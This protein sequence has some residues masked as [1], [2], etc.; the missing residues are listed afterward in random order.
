MARPS[1]SLIFALVLVAAVLCIYL[2]GIGNELVF[3]DSR[4]TDGTVLGQYGSLFTFKPRM[5]SYGSFVWLETLFGSGWWKQ[6]AF[7]IALHLATAF[8][9]YGLLRELFAQTRYSPEDEADPKFSRSRTAALQVGVALFALNPVAVYAVGYLTQRSIVMATLFSVLACW[10]FVRGIASGR[11]WWHLLALIAYLAAVLSKEYAAMIAA[12]ALPLYVYVRRPER[13]TIAIVAGASLALLVAV[14][15]LFFGVYG[16]LVGRLFDERSVAFAR[17]LE[18]LQPGITGRIY[19]LSVF[20]EAALFFKYGLLWFLPNVQWMSLDLRPAFP[21]SY[22]AFPQWLGALGYVALLGGSVWLLIKRRG[23]WS[24]AA[25]LLLFPLLLYPTEFATVWLQD[26][27]VL[28]RSYLWAIAL[29]GLV[30]L[31]LIGFSPRTVYV[32][33]TVVG[34][35]FGVLALDRVLSLK[36]EFSAWSDAAEKIDANAPANAVGRWRPFLNLGAWHL[37]KGLLEQAEGNFQTAIALGDLAGNARFN[38]GVTYQQ[39]KKHEQ[40]LKELAAAEAEGFK[41]QMLY[42]H[43]GESA[44]ALGHFADA[45][46]AFSA[47]LAQAP[48]ERAESSDGARQLTQTLRQRRA[49]AAMATQRY[50]VAVSD[51]SALLKSRPNDPRLMLGMGM[52]LSAKG[53]ARGAL[54]LFDRL[55]AGAPSAPAFYGRAVAR[56]MAGQQGAALAD[57]DQAIALDPRNPQYPQV[58]SQ[59]AA[60]AAAGAR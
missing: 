28:Y 4:L 26:P 10:A 1:N 5:L 14:A 45:Y 11:L 48:E 42:Y 29:P 44:M 36:D 46:Q 33:G 32:C 12:M 57:I 30:A 52:A 6:R 22:G 7:N 58:R 2:P 19:G 53:D 59:L 24:L 56:Y 17:Q 9:L 31:V 15:L 27:F 47:G 3:D 43:R 16:S 39:Q 18:Q 35:L 20:N 51:F 55:V 37:E 34:L 49:D 54:P 60:P 13:R 41:G 21:L 50:D 38:L 23:G 40:A 8:A 25:L